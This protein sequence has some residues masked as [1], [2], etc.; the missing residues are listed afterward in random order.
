MRFTLITATYN[1]EATLE[2]CISSVSTQHHTD[3]EHLVVDGGSNNATMQILMQYQKRGFLQLV[4]SEPDEGVYDAFNKA[5][6]LIT[7]DWVLFLGSDDW[8]AGPKALSD[9]AGE[10]NAL[11]ATNPKNNWYFMA[12]NS[13]SPKGKQ[14]G[15]SP[16]SSA[17]LQP[18]HWTHR[19][20]GS[21][22]LPPHPSLM[23]AAEVFRLGAR[24]DSSY[25][26]C[27]DQKLL[28]LH[29]CPKRVAWIPVNLTV[30]SPGG[31]SQ[32]NAHA[33]LHHRERCRLLRE[34]GRVR[35]VWIERAIEMKARIRQLIARII[36]YSQGSDKTL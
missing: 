19:W 2:R 30:H 29:Q 25:Q 23:H 3:L 33:L 6:E 10:I 7:G 28:W 14:L 27:A 31:L 15:I 9:A 26:I 13:V 32:S 22:P 36:H 12:A 11:Q 35:P 34:I 5:I 1:S 17:W 16:Q 8:L 18:D 24:F 20:R 4:C 21:L